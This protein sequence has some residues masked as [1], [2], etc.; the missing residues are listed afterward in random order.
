[1]IDSAIIRFG[2][3]AAFAA[4]IATGLGLSSGPAAAA[5]VCPDIGQLQ[6]AGQ[7]TKALKNPVLAKSCA[8]GKV[9][10]VSG[11]DLVGQSAKR[12][13]SG[14]YI[15]PNFGNQ[16]IRISATHVEVSK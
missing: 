8:D 11:A 15:L 5:N 7:I 12:V 6:D 10:K 16:G 4:L 14:G 13:G 2:A 1:M 3:G 9:T